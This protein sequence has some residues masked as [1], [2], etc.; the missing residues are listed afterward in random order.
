MVQQSLKVFS[1]KRQLPSTG[2]YTHDDSYSNSCYY[3][4]KIVEGS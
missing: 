3:P 2:I 4:R 1:C